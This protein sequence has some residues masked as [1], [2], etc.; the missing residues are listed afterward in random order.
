MKTRSGLRSS[1]LLLG[2]AALTAGCTSSDQGAS[3][4]QDAA[5]QADLL[6]Y[7][8]MVDKFMGDGVMALFGAPLPREDHAE[9]AVRAGLHLLRRIESAVQREGG[10][11]LAVGIGI[12][13]GEAVVGSVGSAARLEY[14]AIGDAVNVASRLQEMA[15]SGAMLISEETHALLPKELARPGRPL[16]PV[17]VRGRSTPVTAYEY[18]PSTDVVGNTMGHIASP[19][20]EADR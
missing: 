20:M 3:T 12:H 17:T 2:I 15:G 6:L 16:P 1:I 4:G 11:K 13:S 10:I 19:A 14:T 9:A 18:M 8:G 5:V 7:G